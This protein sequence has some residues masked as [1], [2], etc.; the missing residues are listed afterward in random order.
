LQDHSVFGD[1]QFPRGAQIRFSE[2]PAL[3]VTVTFDNGSSIDYSCSASTQ[4]QDLREFVWADR[5]IGDSPFDLIA[6][7]AALADTD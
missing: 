6:D 5:K 3:P 7:G 2:L 1:Y 4:L